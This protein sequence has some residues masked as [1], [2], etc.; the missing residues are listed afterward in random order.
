MVFDILF[1]VGGVSGGS[2]LTA[3]TTIV[4]GDGN[5][6]IWKKE[7]MVCVEGVIAPFCFPFLG[8]E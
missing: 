6:R 2:V 8:I 5:G 3:V 7:G 4:G 1:L